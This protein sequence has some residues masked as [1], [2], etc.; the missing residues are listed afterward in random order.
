APCSVAELMARGFDY[1]ALGHVHIRAVHQGAATVVMPGIPQA[2]DIGEAGAKT[3]TLVS[4]ADDGDIQLQERSVAVAQFERVAIGLSDIA[5]W[6]SGIGHLGQA[7][8]QVRRDHGADHLVVRAMLRGSSRLFW[9]AQRDGDLLL[10]EAEA[11][12]D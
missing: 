8:R 9:Q 2:R 7:L 3:V 12:A 6:S 10:A 4:I 5:D 11:V 1:W